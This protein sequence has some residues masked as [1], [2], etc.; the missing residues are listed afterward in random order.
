MV[1][2]RTSAK[3]AGSRAEKLVADHMMVGLGDDRI[4]RRVR[5]G[6]KDRGDIGGVRSAFGERVVVEVKDT[7]RT[8]LGTWM[9]EVETEK[10][11]DDAPVGVVV[12]K[13][14]GY[15][16]T[17]VG[18]W[19]VTMTLDDFLRILGGPDPEDNT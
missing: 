6:N 2:N 12:H 4:E 13:R 17:R 11:N 19:Y 15:G 3:A 14:V 1:R 16:A 18:G 10:G 5:N 7:T 9:S 8:T